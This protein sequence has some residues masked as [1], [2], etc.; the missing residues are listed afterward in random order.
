MPHTP[1][2]ST[3]RRW[4]ALARWSRTH[5]VA[6]SEAASRFTAWQRERRDLL[7]GAAVS[8]VAAAAPLGLGACQQTRDVA[9]VRVGIVG[10]GVAG[11]HCAWRLVEAGFDVTVFEANDRV[12][13]RMWTARGELPDDQIFEI[14]GELIDSNHLTLFAL[15]DEFGITLDDRWS[16]EIDG[17]TRETNYVGGER[18]SSATLLEQTLAVADAVAADFAG[19]ETDDD[20]FAT[21]NQQPLSAWLDAR[22]PAADYPELHEILRVAYVGEFGLEVDEQ[23]ALNLIYL[24][25]FDSEDEFLIFGDSDER[26]HTHLGND[27][28]TTALGDAIGAARIQLGHKLVA[29]SGRGRG[30]FTLTFEPTGGGDPVTA[31]VDHLVFALPFTTLRDV[32]LTELDLS[33]EKR[34][35]IDEIGYGTNAKVM[36]SFTRRPWW[37]DHGETGLLTTDLPVQ[38]GWDTTIG[39]SGT[40]GVWTNFLGGDQG[41]A[42][43]G[44]EAADWFDGVLDDLEVLWPGTRAAWTGDAWRM[45]WPTFPWSKGSYTCYKPGQ[46]DFWGLEGVRERNVHFCGEHCS[47]DFQGWMEG[48][49]ETGGLVAAEIL[50]DHGVERPPSLERAVGYALRLP[51]PCFQ[52]DQYGPKTWKDRRAVL[53]ALRR[54]RR[55]LARDRR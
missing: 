45:H 44:G 17:M 21:L 6:P 42:S 49:A 35:I 2:F 32:D 9:S 3:L 5:G 55:L 33:D 10:A 41:T 34:Q 48:A 1:A 18:V 12:G 15:A 29:A 26:W 27:T 52:G 37:D 31:E 46:W 19:A 8:A 16:F 39:Q 47:L 28:F 11:L 24:F 38:Q 54:E 14:G 25:G 22:V 30:P 40:H 13:G 4:F 50:D 51:N 53:K 23:S 20:A 7:R 36:G 43:A